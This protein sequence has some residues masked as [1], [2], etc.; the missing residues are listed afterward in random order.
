MGSIFRV[1]VIKLVVIGVGLI[2]LLFVVLF[3]KY[4][5]M[6]LEIIWGG[7]FGFGNWKGEVFIEYFL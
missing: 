7:E 3:G 2:S 4:L 1:V 6:V 5:V